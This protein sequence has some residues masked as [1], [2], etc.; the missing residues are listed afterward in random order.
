MPPKTNQS[1]QEKNKD[2][3]LPRAEFKPIEAEGGKWLRITTMIVGLV[4]IM[5]AGILYWFFYHVPSS[6]PSRKTHPTH[7]TYKNGVAEADIDSVDGGS[8]VQHQATVRDAKISSPAKGLEA[9]AGEER[10]QD[11]NALPHTAEPQ[12][13]II[14][15]IKTSRG[16]YYVVVG[17]FIDDDLAADYANRLAQ[18]GVDVMLI[19]PSQGQYYFRVAIEKED[20]FYDAYEKLKVLKATYGADIWVLKY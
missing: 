10:V 1:P 18:Q 2:F 5:G 15:S 14:T 16:Y 6:D 11:V 13:G 8:P 19:A 4:L 12:K 3:G 7:E 17:S 20:S 9:S